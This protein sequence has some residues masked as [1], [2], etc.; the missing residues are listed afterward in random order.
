MRVFGL[1]VLF[2]TAVAAVPKAGQRIVGGS[3][4]TISQYPTIAGL[5]FTWSTNHRQ[6][7]GSVILNN[8]HIMTAA[9][10]TINHPP[11]RFRVRTGSTF[12]NSGG[13]VHIVAVIFNHPN[14]N[15][16]TLD[17]DIATMRTNNLIMFNTNTQPAAIAGPNYN[18]AD[19]QVV[20]AAGWG[21]TNFGGHLSETLRHVQMWSVNHNLC[22][23]R[24]REVGWSL[25]SRMLCSGWL[26]VGGRDQCQGDSGGPLYHN[27][28]VVGI[29]SFGEQCGLARYPGV[30]TRISSFT[31]WIQSNS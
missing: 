1:L 4:T 12:A 29:C 17:N 15:S 2:F 25:T 18:V 31:S 23:N 24:Y 10:C 14:Y 21:S 13:V 26:D 27:N 20:W 19:N 6:S 5:L 8:R 22:T 11:G 9:H 28:V 16:V 7:C 3:T 30:N